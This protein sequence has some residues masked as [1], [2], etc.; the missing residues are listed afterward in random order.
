MQSF[1]TLPSRVLS[2]EDHKF[3]V[4]VSYVPDTSNAGNSDIDKN[5]L[6]TGDYLTGDLGVY[7]HLF[8]LGGVANTH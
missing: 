5:N 7:L 8:F 4:G 3:Q 2:N 6:H 1:L